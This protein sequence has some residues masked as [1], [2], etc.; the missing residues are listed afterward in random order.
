MKHK[1]IA[2]T[3]CFNENKIFPFVLDYW[4]LFAD[5][6]VVYDNGSTD[7]ILTNFNKY[8]D[9]IEVR[10]FDTHNELSDN[11]IQRIKSECYKESIGKCD[12]VYVGEFD[13][14]MWAQN[15]DK[16]LDYMDEHNQ[17]IVLPNIY[18]MRCLEFP[19]YTNDKLLHQYNDIHF[20][21]NDEFGKRILFNPNKINVTY[22]AGGHTCKCSG[23]VNYYDNNNIYLFHAKYLGYKYLYE[24]QLAYHNR[25]SANDI[26]EHLNIHLYNKPDFNKIKDEQIA[27]YNNCRH[28]SF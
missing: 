23:I 3:V 26:K 16:E 1:I 10:H 21:R 18:Q 4:K 19:T 14:L 17:T 12:Y 27:A 24:R 2:Y 7:G 20:E 6:V 11:V 13:E 22:G 8:K 25:L 15:L 5:K 9:F 28:I